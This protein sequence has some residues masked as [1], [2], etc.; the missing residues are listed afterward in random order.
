MSRIRNMHEESLS[1]HED[2]KGMIGVRVK[3]PV[4]DLD[5]LTLAYSPGVAEPCLEINKNPDMLGVY[6]NHG[7]SI[8][9][10]TNGSAVMGL[11]N[12]GPKA[13][14]PMAEGMALIFKKF[15]DVDAM[16]V[17]IN[18]SDPGEIIEAIEMLR[19]TFAGVN[20]ADIKAP[21]CF[22]IESRL[23][24]RGIFQGPVFHDDQHG[25][26]IVT[27]A[28]LINA[29]KIVGKRLDNIKIAIN[30]A[31]ASGM[32]T[33]KLLLKVGC[34]HM[35]VC[36]SKGTLYD[37]R[38]RNMNPY[39]Q[40]LAKLTNR[41]NVRGGLAEALKGADVFI[42]LSAPNILTEGM[43]KSMAKDPIVFALANPSPEISPIQRA[44]DAGA[45]VVAS[46]CSDCPNQLIDILAFPGIFRGALDV[47]ATDIN[48]AMKIAA[49]YALADLVPADELGP[50]RIVPS[51]LDPNTAPAVASAS[52][53]AAMDTGVARIKVD[54]AVVAENLRQRLA[55]NQACA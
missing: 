31:G 6:T 25:A 4:N 35:I 20:I 49:A 34:G 3:I 5:D 38:L 43:I 39:K 21:E 54:P 33:A 13:A 2:S 45:A 14:L 37:G 32:A 55:A 44:V 9:I 46:G 42:G 11:G 28:G 7:N 22:E 8:C 30:G 50:D 53:R 26:A 48:D 52:A 29:L 16:P 41:E 24:K 19:P 12:I 51:Y 23:K 15:G 27:L 40:E 1:L 10:V 47:R 18:S 17:C 36:D